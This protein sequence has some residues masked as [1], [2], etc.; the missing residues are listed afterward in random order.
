MYERFTDRAR[1][2]CQLANQ[3]AQRLNYKYIDVYCMTIG[4]CKADGIAVK[5]LERF[6]IDTNLLISNI[7]DRFTPN[8]NDTI[9]IGKLEHT[10]SLQKVLQYAIVAADELSHKYVG[11]EHILLGCIKE[12]FLNQLSINLSYE[13]TK[14]ELLKLLYYYSVEEEAPTKDLLNKF[15]VNTE[16]RKKN[17]TDKSI[18]IYCGLGISSKYNYHERGDCGDAILELDKDSAIKHLTNEVAYLTKRVMDLECA[19]SDMRKK[20]NNEST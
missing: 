10:T 18:C 7:R 1:I 16:N 2:A 15:L 3:E 20:Q 19:V 13:E 9:T 4:I 17:V 5:L 12:G 8:T 11:T 6:G 14:E